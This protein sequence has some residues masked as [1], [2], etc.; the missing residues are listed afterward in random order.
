MLEVSGADHGMMLPGP[1]HKSAEV[2]GQ[3][4]TAVETFLDDV[5]WP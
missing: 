1:L 2:L 4:T 3:V 5:I